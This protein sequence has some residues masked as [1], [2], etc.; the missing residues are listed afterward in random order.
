MLLFIVS[1]ISVNM[2][3]CELKDEL[4]LTGWMAHK[5]RNDMKLLNSKKNIAVSVYWDIYMPSFIDI[6]QI[7]MTS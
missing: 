7:L 6:N 4:R 1:I 2:N 3:Q 5:V